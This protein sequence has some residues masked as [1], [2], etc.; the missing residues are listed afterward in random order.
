MIRR[1]MLV[2]GHALTGGGGV[3][4]KMA[5]GLVLLSWRKFSFIHAIISSNLISS[6]DR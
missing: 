2:I 4:A 1:E 5:S 3:L 6:Q